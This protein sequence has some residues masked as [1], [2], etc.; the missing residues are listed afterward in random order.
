MIER[1]GQVEEV[2]QSEDHSEPSTV[3]SS[4]DFYTLDHKLITLIGVNVEW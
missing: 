4:L 3:T 1:N 2:T